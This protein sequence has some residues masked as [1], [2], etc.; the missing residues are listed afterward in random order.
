[1][2]NLAISMLLR[3]CQGRQGVYFCGSFATPGNGHDLSLLS[4][5]A[6]AHIIGAPYPF[7]QDAAARRD[8]DKLY[9]LML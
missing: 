5:M 2:R 7:V 4:G 8:F 9:R 1:M 6:I 3:F